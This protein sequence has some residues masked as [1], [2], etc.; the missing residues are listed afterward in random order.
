MSPN[1]GASADVPSAIFFERNRAFLCVFKGRGGS[2]EDHH[3]EV[4]PGGRTITIWRQWMRKGDVIFDG[5]YEMSGAQ[6]RLRGRFASQA[7]EA[8]LVLRRRG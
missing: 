7:G 4:N 5:G 1:L 6:L 8:A 2:Y 3:F